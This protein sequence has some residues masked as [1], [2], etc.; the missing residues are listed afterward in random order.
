MPKSA[1][2]QSLRKPSPK[3]RLYPHATVAFYGPDD[4]FATKVAVA[5]IQ[6]PGQSP[7]EHAE[8]H[9][10]GV[11]V[12]EDPEITQAIVGWITARGI[13]HSTI[14]EEIVGCPHTAGVDHPEGERC[15][16]CDFWK[17]RSSVTSR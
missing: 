9:F 3:P 2:R 16:L 1:S 7:S 8:W 15:P 11:D 12:R 10:K 13:T 4:R 6:G 14:A 5:A 17:N